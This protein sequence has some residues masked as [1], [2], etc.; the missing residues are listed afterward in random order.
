MSTFE[1]RLSFQMFNFMKNNHE[2]TAKC[3]WGS[4]YAVSSAAGSWR[5]HGG[6]SGGEAPEN[7]LHFY[8]WRVNEQV[9]IEK[10]K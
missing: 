2:I 7:L 5:S 3:R 8:I 6:V 1:L 10:T 4:G 9:K